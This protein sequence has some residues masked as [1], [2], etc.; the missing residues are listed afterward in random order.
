MLSG[1][2]TSLSTANTP[3]LV[4]EHRSVLGAAMAFYC[5]TCN[6]PACHLCIPLQHPVGAHTVVPIAEAAAKLSSGLTASIDECRRRII[7][8]TAVSAQ[9]QKSVAAASV[10][11]QEARA[12]L[13]AR[14]EKLVAAIRWNTASLD[15]ALVKISAE[16]VVAA[17]A[18]DR[19]VLGTRD[20]C[21]L[22]V[23]VGAAALECGDAVTIAL[24][25]ASVAMT[26]EC[27][28]A[29]DLLRA[30]DCSVVFAP[31]PTPDIRFML[32][33]SDVGVTIG[34]IALVAPAGD[35]QVW[36]SPRVR[37]CAGVA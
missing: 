16:C 9:S 19:R 33:G 27:V 25:A 13:A 31:T 35:V 7:E 14:S 18:H 32:Q 23:A 22:G 37:T 11:L 20:E 30:P 8:L 34:A 24:S 26:K 15:A 12:L 2:A 21:V 3:C 36:I 17:Q 28:S 5:L 29:S 6:E 4:P 10:S 1:T